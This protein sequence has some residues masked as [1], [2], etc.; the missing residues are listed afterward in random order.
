MTLNLNTQVHQPLNS[1]EEQQEFLS[2]RCQSS[3][4]KKLLGKMDKKNGVL[5]IESS[6]SG[7]WISIKLERGT[8]LCKK[9]GNE[10]HWDHTKLG[11]KNGN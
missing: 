11:E 9:C 2:L 8:I 3:Q 7:W 5:H 10:L 1:E 4:C 6:R